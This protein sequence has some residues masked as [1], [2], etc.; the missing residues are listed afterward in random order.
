MKFVFVRGGIQQTVDESLVAERLKNVKSDNKHSLN[1]SI[2]GFER[3]V[4]KLSELSL[5]DLD[6]LCE[7]SGNS[8]VI[9]ITTL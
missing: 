2:R 6:K 9:Q 5:S 4:V 3:G 8:L 1:L 7:R